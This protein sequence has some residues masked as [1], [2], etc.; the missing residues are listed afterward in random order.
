LRRHGVRRFVHTSTVGIHG[1]I[2]GSPAIETSPIR[3][4]GIYEVTKAEGDAAALAAG[5]NKGLPEVVVLRPAPVYG[6]GDTRLLKLFKLACTRRPILLGDGRAL[7]QMVHID[8]LVT[9]FLQAARMPAI[10]GEAFIIAGAERPTVEG[11]LGTVAQ[12]LGRAEPPHPIR[13]PAAP[14]RLLAHAC[15]LACQPLGIKPPLYRRR[16]DF[17]LLNRQ[18]DTTKAARMLSYAPAVPLVEG[19]RGT[20]A[21]YRRKGLLPPSLGSSGL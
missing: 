4:D 12:I 14:I 13:L 8:D 3:P 19:L 11:L 2:D 17:F 15:E 18:Y 6:P 9:A 7:Y 5:S 1:S 10:G 21:W 20:A 16:V